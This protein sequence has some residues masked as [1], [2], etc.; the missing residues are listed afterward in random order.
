MA[1]QNKT[2]KADPFAGKS[3]AAQKADAK[4]AEKQTEAEDKV[5]EAKAQG[6]QTPEEEAKAASTN[7]ELN[8]RDASNVESVSTTK[9]QAKRAQ[10]EGGEVTSKNTDDQTQAPAKAETKAS[11]KNGQKTASTAKQIK[12]EDL[13]ATIPAEDGSHFAIIQ[14]K[15]GQVLISIRPDLW[16]GEAPLNVTREDAEKIH[17]L[18]GE[19]VDRTKELVN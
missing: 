14:D 5:L 12:R 2:E 18:L 7:P 8:A 3:A 10:T 6:T 19:A 15:T 9:E 13:P 17:A 16:V 11:K 4:A 1:A